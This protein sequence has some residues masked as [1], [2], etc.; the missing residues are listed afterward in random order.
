[1][2]TTS[3]SSDVAPQEL[4]AQ[5]RRGEPLHVVD[6]R[7]YPEYAAARID[8]ARLIPSGEITTRVQELDRNEPLVLVCRSGRRSTAALEKLRALG[9]S[10]A[11]QL[12]GGMEAWQKEE[13][14]VTRDKR[15]PWA[16]ERQVRLVAGLLILTGLV[17]SKFWP[18]AIMLAWFVPCGLV[19]A[20]L[21]DSC[22]MGMLL[23]KL[24]W[25]RSESS[26]PSQGTCRA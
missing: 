13:L 18:P 3:Y 25:N 12:K 17:G 4:H 10:N 1:M 16:L 19:F 20:A 7:E 2:S 15:A 14:P 22:A 24:P 11:V 26:G 21:T 23:A 9:F 6:V 8:G 5:L